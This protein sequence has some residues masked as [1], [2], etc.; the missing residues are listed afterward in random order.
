MFHWLQVASVY[1]SMGL[2][3]LMLGDPT[4]TVSARAGYARQEGSK[5]GRN[6]CRV[7]NVIDLKNDG[8]DPDGDHCDNAQVADFKRAMKR[9]GRKP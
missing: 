2:N 4:M 1:F 6:V 7:L 9:Q 8:D 5:V 3:T